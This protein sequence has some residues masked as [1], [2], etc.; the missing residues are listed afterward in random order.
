[1]QLTCNP[2]LC[3]DK[4]TKKLCGQVLR[5]ASLGLRDVLLEMVPK[6]VEC[7]KSKKSDAIRTLKNNIADNEFLNI[8]RNIK[9]KVEKLA[10]E[11][12]SCHAQK[13]KQDK[14]KIIESACR[15]KRFS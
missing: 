1:M 10:R 13:Y 3:N 11:I 6:K 7:L 8:S 14:I 5:K 2:S 15:N 12:K 9:Q 4:A